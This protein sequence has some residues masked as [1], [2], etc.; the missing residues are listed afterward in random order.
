MPRTRARGASNEQTCTEWASGMPHKAPPSSGLHRP[1]DVPVLPR[2]PGLGA[3]GLGLAQAQKSFYTP[4][5]CALHQNSSH[6]HQTHDAVKRGG[7]RKTGQGV[8]IAHGGRCTRGM[9]PKEGELSEGVRG[10][11]GRLPL[12]NAATYQELST[13][14]HSK[15]HDFKKERE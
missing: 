15:A 1:E 3:A 13:A 4:Q 8:L 7:A 2:G 9:R 5:N 14:I 11:F 10:T 12:F 6:R